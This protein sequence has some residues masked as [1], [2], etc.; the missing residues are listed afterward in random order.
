MS[1]PIELCR[2]LDHL[3]NSNYL[4]IMIVSQ[5]VT[6]FILERSCSIPKLNCQLASRFAT[7][8]P[9]LYLNA[10][11]LMTFYLRL[12]QPSCALLTLNTLWAARA[13]DKGFQGVQKR[14]DS[15][16]TAVYSSIRV[17]FLSESDSLICS[18]LSFC[19]I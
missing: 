19:S 7:L 9:L 3:S 13:R 6:R 12:I 4:L 8:Y 16:H 11:A 15:F 18:S 2:V 14:P 10:D 5:N 1:H 17:R